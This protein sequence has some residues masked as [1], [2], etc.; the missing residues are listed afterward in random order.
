[1]NSDPKL[2]LFVALEAERKPLQR[3]SAQLSVHQCGPGHAN[4]LHA[5]LACKEGQLFGNIGLSGGLTKQ[6]KAG[7]LVLARQ[8]FGHNQQGEQVCY[9][10]DTRQSDLL[11]EK[12]AVAGLRL[13][14]GMVACVSSPLLTPRAKADLGQR[15]GALTVDM[16]SAAL[17]EAAGELDKPFFCL[18]VVCDPVHRS[19]R[20]QLLVGVD[21]RGNNRPGRLVLTLLQHPW[22]LPP[23]IAMLRDYNQAARTLTRLGPIFADLFRPEKES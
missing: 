17:A 16:E 18:R 20:E 9:E 11:A 8:I 21:D 22:L 23:F 15:T 6:L 13:H 4:A 1:M 12:I 5:A 14:E 2:A 3:D 10:T 7:D 19:L